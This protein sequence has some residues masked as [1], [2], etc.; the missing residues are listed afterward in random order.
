MANPATG[1]SVSPG[2]KKKQP[3]TAK[4][5]NYPELKSYEFQSKLFM[6]SALATWM[7]DDASTPIGKKAT[8]KEDHIERIRMA[9][10]R[11]GYLQIDKTNK[12]LGLSDAVTRF[13][14]ERLEDQNGDARLEQLSGG[15]A[16][17]KSK[18]VLG[19]TGE[20]DRLTV[21]LLDLELVDL[22]AANS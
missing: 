1:P 12:W 19:K 15:D 10:R 6:G 2:P 9:F 18:L 14:K 17:K 7:T 21:A 13:Q 20:V 16:D 5:A 11:L 8:G 4:V 3:V 22:E